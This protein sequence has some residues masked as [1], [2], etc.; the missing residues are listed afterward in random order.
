METWIDTESG[1]WETACISCCIN[2]S[3]NFILFFRSMSLPQI[4][5]LLHHVFFFPVKSWLT[6]CQWQ[7]AFEKKKWRNCPLKQDCLVPC[8]LDVLQSINFHHC[9]W[10]YLYGCIELIKKGTVDWFLTHGLKNLSWCLFR[11]NYY[12]WFTGGKKSQKVRVFNP[13]M[14]VN[15]KWRS[16]H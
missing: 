10:L 3:C 4:N 1:G 14:F 7:I 12:K 2:H 16:L 9:R 11:W 13:S 6:V 8:H 5:E 15:D